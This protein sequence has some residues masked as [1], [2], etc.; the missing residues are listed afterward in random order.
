[1]CGAL[2]MQAS[3]IVCWL[4]IFI[5]YNIYRVKNSKV[6]KTTNHVQI[7]SPLCKNYEMTTII[8]MSEVIESAMIGL[9]TFLIV[10]S[11]YESITQ[12]VQRDKTEFIS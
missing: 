2:S 12:W 4:I 11:K 8:I 5:E 7:T 3:T 6:T 1:M 10:L 9:R